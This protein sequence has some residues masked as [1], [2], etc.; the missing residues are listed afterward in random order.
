MGEALTAKQAAA[1]AAAKLALEAPAAAGVDERT[2]LPMCGQGT[3]CAGS[4]TCRDTRCQGRGLG[5]GLPSKS[6]PPEDDWLWFF[7]WI[8]CIFISVVI[9]GLWAVRGDLIIFWSAK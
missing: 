2:C 1:Y 3:A 4:K 7:L 6:G 9:G 8:F 5:E